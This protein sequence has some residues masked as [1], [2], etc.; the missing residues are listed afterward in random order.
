[1]IF[2]FHYLLPIKNTISPHNKKISRFF[3]DIFL[4]MARDS[5]TKNNYYENI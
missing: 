4:L 1:M 3:S 2:E 5:N